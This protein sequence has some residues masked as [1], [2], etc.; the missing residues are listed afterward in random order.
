MEI[1]SIADARFGPEPESATDD[2]AKIGLCLSDPVAVSILWLLR[3]GELCACEIKQTLASHGKGTFSSLRKLRE[4]N[5][6]RV[7]RRDQWFAFSL[8]RRYADLV[9]TVFECAEGD[10]HQ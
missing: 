4:A 10:I 8:R 2:L 9:E 5:L 6:I 7:R 3:H 1:E